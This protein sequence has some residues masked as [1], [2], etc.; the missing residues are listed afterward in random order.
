M[1]NSVDKLWSVGGS[2][3]A[4]VEGVIHSLRGD[5]TKPANN[6]VVMQKLYTNCTRVYARAFTY[7]IS[8][9]TKLY[10]ISTSTITTSTMYITNYRSYCL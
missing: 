5:F 2:S 7:F 4:Q 1:S 9:I 8:V 10:P 3:G 6:Y